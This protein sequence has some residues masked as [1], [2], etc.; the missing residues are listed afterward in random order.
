M[1]T[2]AVF[3]RRPSDLG[4]P[5]GGGSSRT[6]HHRRGGAQPGFQLSLKGGIAKRSAVRRQTLDARV[7]RAIEVIDGPWA[8]K[9]WLVWCGLNDEETALETRARSLLRRH[10]RSVVG[11]DARI[12]RERGG[13]RRQVRGAHHASRLSSGSG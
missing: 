13:A 9:P 5:D 11:R 2:W 1:A 3:V 8:G 10:Q 6:E 7:K 4:Y 12:E